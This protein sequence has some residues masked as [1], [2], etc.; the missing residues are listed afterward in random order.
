MNKLYEAI[1]LFR[2]R[3]D[4]L[5][6]KVFVLAGTRETKLA[7]TKLQSA[8]MWMGKAL[9][10]WGSENPYTPGQ[11]IPPQDK[12]EKITHAAGTR[13]EKITVLREEAQNL[14]DDLQRFVVPQEISARGL[15]Y[16]E[17]GILH[18]IE[19]KMWLG[20]EV[21]NIAAEEKTT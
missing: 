17:Q 16:F 4:A 12:A 18:L 7:Y 14:I 8:K 20:M 15:V 13:L 1:H 10:E 21:P 2:L 5:S 9:G 11:P 19:A 3:V 6:Q